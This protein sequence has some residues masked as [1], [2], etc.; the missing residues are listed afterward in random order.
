PESSCLLAHTGVCELVKENFQG[1]SHAEGLQARS[2]SR[3][4]P[5]PAAQ[6]RKNVAAFCGAGA[7]ARVRP[8]PRGPGLESSCLLAH[9]GVCE[10]VK[11]NFQSG[12]HA[13]GLQARSISRA[14]PD[15]AARRRKH[16]AAFVARA[17]SPAYALAWNQAASSLTQERG[18]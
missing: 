14:V 7:L 12:S 4:V 16:V 11:E 6:R 10:L 5:H 13:E 1:G 2:I 15:P 3:A 8:R 18:G 9:T 17:P